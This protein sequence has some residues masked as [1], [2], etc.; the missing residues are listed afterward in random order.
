MP[1]GDDLDARFNELVAQIDTD[2]R[3]RMRAAA[4]KGAKEQ[5]RTDRVERRPD[6]RLPD[7]LY[8]TEPRP[9]PRRR[10]GR[11]WIAMAVITGLIA[12]AGV[13]VTYRP[14]LLTPSSVVA[15]GLAPVEAAPMEL[16]NPF[17]GSPADDY[18][19]GIGGFVMPEPKAMAGLSKKDVAKGLERTR[20]LLAAAFLDRRTLIDGRPDAFAELLHPDLRKAFLHDLEHDKKYGPGYVLRFAPGTA[21]LATDVIKVHG[22]ATLGTYKEDGMRAVEVKLNHLVVYALRRPRSPGSPIRF[23]A[24][25]T[26]SV[27]LYRESG[28]LVVW[29]TD[30]GTSH[31]PASC[32]VHDGFVHPVYD[33]SPPEK[34][35]PS[36][37][38]VDPYALEEEDDGRDCTWT[39]PT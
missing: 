30:W 3:R 35:Q 38:P 32:D 22:T 6:K 12:G 34:V 26:G 8:E 2:E 18:A 13:L 29:P 37:P 16:V 28:R 14:D 24:H 23:V 31:A 10:A 5:R 1:H 4:A 39:E 21:E 17:A 9:R 25:S 20:E 33:D 36:G 15:E 11:A 27:L 7:R 19:E